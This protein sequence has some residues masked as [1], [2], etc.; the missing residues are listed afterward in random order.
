M[1]KFE[2]YI[3]NLAVLEKAED[4]DLNNDFIVGGIINKFFIQFEL[5]WKTLKELLV[6]EGVAVAA[7]G[8]PRDIIK[9]SYKYYDWMD[10]AVWLSMLTQ[11]NSVAHIYNFEAAEKLVDRIIKDYIPA[12]ILMRDSVERKYKDILDTL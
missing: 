9:E 7:S 2:N 5:G 10:E 1:K 3:A 12:F 4:Q 8:S 6:Y 11:R